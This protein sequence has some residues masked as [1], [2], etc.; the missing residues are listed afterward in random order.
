MISV[1]RMYNLIG[2]VS[3]DLGI[4]P[5]ELTDKL[6]ERPTQSTDTEFFNELFTLYNS[7][8]A[9]LED[10]NLNSARRALPDET[11][12]PL[13]C[14]TYYNW[15][16]EGREYCFRIA[17]TQ[18]E[19]KIG[20]VYI[21]AYT[22]YCLNNLKTFLIAPRIFPYIFVFPDKYEHSLDA[23]GKVI[24]LKV[25]SKEMSVKVLQVA[26]SGKAYFENCFGLD[27][28]VF[29]SYLA[30]S[31]Y[32]MEYMRKY[33]SKERVVDLTQPKSTHKLTTPHFRNGHNRTY[34]SGKT[35]FVR[36]TYV[37]PHK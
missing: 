33:R 14:N 18:T 15:V 16:I 22:M 2:K 6:H 3:E 17:D 20:N 31:L 7:Y 30:E 26:S 29:S 12:W 34:K 11:D 19:I 1:N 23:I 25:Q 5:R 35:V 27:Y 13:L 10:V 9:H 28:N 32:R 21:P 37:V 4:P 24:K 8:H 36:P